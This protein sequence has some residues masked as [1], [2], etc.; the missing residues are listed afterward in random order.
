LGGL[1]FDI[2]GSVSL[3]D[4]IS[5]V[6]AERLAWQVSLEEAFSSQK[7]IIYQVISED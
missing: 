5:S 6:K 2:N 3:D 4:H 1:I 7:K